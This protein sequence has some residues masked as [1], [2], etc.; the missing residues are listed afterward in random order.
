MNA[1]HERLLHVRARQPVEDPVPLLPRPSPPPADRLAEHPCPQCGSREQWQTPAG[2]W[3]CRPCL[4]QA[5]IPI[6]AVQVWREVLGTV[7][8]V[9]ADDLP[10]GEWPQET[11]VY[12]RAEVRLLTQIRS[13]ALRETLAWVHAVKDLFQARVVRAQKGAGV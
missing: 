4:L 1:W 8:W 6:A 10:L 2:G 12:T 9:V 13:E 3:I 11:P 5:E 7:V